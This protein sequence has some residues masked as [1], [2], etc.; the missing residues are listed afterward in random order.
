[1]HIV[2]VPGISNIWYEQ[3]VAGVSPLCH[4]KHSLQTQVPEKLQHPVFLRSV[5]HHRVAQLDPR[6][7]L[8]ENSNINNSNTNAKKKHVPGVI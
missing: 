3:K 5:Q 1:M 6:E 4:G 2:R 8:N 7:V